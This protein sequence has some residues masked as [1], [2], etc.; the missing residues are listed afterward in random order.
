MSLHATTRRRNYI[1]LI[2]SEMDQAFCFQCICPNLN[3]WKVVWGN[4]CVRKLVNFCTALN[5]K[6]GKMTLFGPMC[7]GGRS[8][9]HWRD[10][11]NHVTLRGK[12]DDDD[13]NDDGVWKKSQQTKSQMIIWYFV[14]LDDDDDDD[15]RLAKL[16]SPCSFQ[17]SHSLLLGCNTFLLPFKINT[18]QCIV[19]PIELHSAVCYLHALNCEN[20]NINCT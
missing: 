20:S 3:I 14:H 17:P 13:D 16:T 10:I 2:A 7:K 15:S 9:A 18:F 1:L 6:T 19:K 12:G 8:Q 5:G 4:E 11:Y